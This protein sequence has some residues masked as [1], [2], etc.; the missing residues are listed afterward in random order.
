MAITRINHFEAK[1]ERQSELGAFLESIIGL[2][3]T[4]AGCISCQLLRAL[5]APTKFVIV[6]VWDSVDSHQAAAKIVP[7]AKIQEIMPLLA[8]PPAGA[9]FLTIDA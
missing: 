1:H 7:V 4:S 3:K 8:S 9:Y 5:D 2:V 6:E